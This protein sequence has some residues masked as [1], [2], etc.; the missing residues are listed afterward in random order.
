MTTT[1]A[2]FEEGDLVR[3]YLN[4][5]GAIPLLT[6][7]QE[8]DLA[9][10]IEAGVYAEALL[11]RGSP[12]SRRDL[13]YL[14][15]DARLAMRRMINANLRL[16]VAVARQH[17]RGRLSL[18]DAIQE[19]NLGLIHAVE[20]FDYTKGYKFSTYATWWIRQAI[21]RGAAH[22]RIVRLPAHVEEEVNRVHAAYH[23][24]TADLGRA[25]GDEELAEA[26]G[27]TVPRVEELRRFA[28]STISLDMPTGEGDDGV[29]FGEFIEDC[30]LPP[31]EEIAE[32]QAL[33]ADVRAAVADLPAREGRAITMRYGLDTGLPRTLR[34][35]AGE[36]GTSRERAR[37]LI[38]RGLR[39]LGS[40]ES[41][42][43]LV[44]WRERQPDEGA[45]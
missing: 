42:H 16:V 38:L 12:R 13:E 21:D 2:G 29:P 34:E 3:V 27:S 7:E 35:I 4:Q 37:Q 41:R 40:P 6:A 8:V 5:I 31:T 11:V 10:R 18:L 30:E 22:N 33:I 9:R 14:A 20:K 45:A 23:K 36:L 39:Q 26:T 44:Q 17:N 43:P 24:L 28:R 19:G 32:H 15:E 1:T 25:P